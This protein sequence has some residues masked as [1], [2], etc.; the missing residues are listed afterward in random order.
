MQLRA[1][2]KYTTYQDSLHTVTIYV[3]ELMLNTL[4]FA[5]LIQTTSINVFS[6]HLAE[7]IFQ[8]LPK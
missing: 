5:R 4:K 2:A 3:R 7:I 1:F 6:E 8:N